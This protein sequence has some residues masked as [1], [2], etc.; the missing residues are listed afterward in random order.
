MKATGIVRRIDDLGR[1]VIP[2]EIRRTLKIREGNSLE[3]YTDSQGNVIFKKYSPIGE[4]DETAEIYAQVVSKMTGKAAFIC[5]NEK[6]V[7]V[8]G[9]PKKEY[10]G[11]NISFALENIINK[12]ESF[13]YDK[14]CK[15]V[16]AFEGGEETV[17]CMTPIIVSSETV[18]AVF[19][20]SDGNEATREM[21]QKLIQ[22]A[23]L[24]LE[25]QLG[26]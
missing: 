26:F 10:L 7:A 24:L 3:I 23:A 5:D 18:G 20:L 22:A 13:I 9:A 19:S 14:N 17:Y 16:K 11:R 2:K 25:K 4:I 12:R 6:V 15:N 8:S 21:E 1:V